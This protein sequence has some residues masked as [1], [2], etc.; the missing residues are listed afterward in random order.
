M[1]ADAV[2]TVNIGPK[3]RWEHAHQ[4]RKCGHIV[5][6][7]EIDA[8]VVAMGVFSCPECET[9]GPIRVTIIPIERDRGHFDKST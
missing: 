7:E 3:T 8:R 6:I 4:C 2:E 9:A 1:G 5:S